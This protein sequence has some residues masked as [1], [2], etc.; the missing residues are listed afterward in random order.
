MQ[1]KQVLAGCNPTPSLMLVGTNISAPA[2]GF[3]STVGTP[4]AISL[5]YSDAPEPV[6]NNVALIVSG[7]VISWTAGAAGWVKVGYP[8]ATGSGS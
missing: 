6:V 5:G 4:V 7:Q 2:G 3:P 1:V 8:P